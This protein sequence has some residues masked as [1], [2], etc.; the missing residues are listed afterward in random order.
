MFEVGSVALTM[1]VVN[2]MSRRGVRWIIFIGL[3]LLL[4]RV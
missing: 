1:F 2:R 3:P 4:C